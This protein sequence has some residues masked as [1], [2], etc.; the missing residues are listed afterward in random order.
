MPTKS[1][2]R[3][4]NLD[5]DAIEKIVKIL[6]EWS[7]PKLTWELLLT[8]IQRRLGA[9]YVRQT[10]DKYARI[11]DAFVARKKTLAARDPNDPSLLT[12]EQKRIVDLETEVARLKRENNN[13]LEQF[14][15][16]T[17]NGQRLQIDHRMRDEWRGLREELDK[18]LQKP[19]REASK[20]MQPARV[21]KP[22]VGDG[23][24]P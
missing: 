8:E 10:L 3:S 15:R 22:L 4:P 16:W 20:V 6:D 2:K 1:R 24:S 23:K 13:L 5:D 18:P 21:P 7:L 12:P 11:S 17:F 14:N 9:R 19:D